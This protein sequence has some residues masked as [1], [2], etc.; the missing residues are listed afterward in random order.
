M[1]R[2]VGK[3]GGALKLLNGFLLGLTNI[4]RTHFLFL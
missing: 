4:K 2:N 3:L 1:G